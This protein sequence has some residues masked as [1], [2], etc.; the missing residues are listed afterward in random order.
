MTG[1]GDRCLPGTHRGFD[2][3]DHQRGAKDRAVKDGADGAIRALPH[4]FEFVLFNAL[5]V[6]SDGGAFHPDAIFLIASAA[7]VVTLSLV[8]SR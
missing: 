6:G 8:S 2:T 1:D 7:A 4:T 3:V 5:G